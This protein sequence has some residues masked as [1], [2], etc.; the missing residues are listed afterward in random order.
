MKPNLRSLKRPAIAFAVG[1]LCLAAG[2]PPAAAQS[3]RCVDLYNRVMAL[4]Q[5]APQSY[6]YNRVANYY[7]GRCL[8]GSSPIPGYPGPY[9]RP[10]SGY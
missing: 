2:A 4:Y 8:T 3:E 6:E 5:T 10:Y 9:Q 1:A 7:S